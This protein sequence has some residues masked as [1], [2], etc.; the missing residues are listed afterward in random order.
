M[1]D[2]IQKNEVE[3]VSPCLA[4]LDL[5]DGAEPII[6]LGGKIVIDARRKESPGFRNGFVSQVEAVRYSGAVESVRK[7]LASSLKYKEPK[8]IQ[9][10]LI[11]NTLIESMWGSSFKNTESAKVIG[12]IPDNWRSDQNDPRYYYSY[13]EWQE[14]KSELLNLPKPS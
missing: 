2:I 6:K 4:I 7:V 14:V 11:G 3:M 13:D 9:S 5:R 8:N 12:G 10:K 1:A